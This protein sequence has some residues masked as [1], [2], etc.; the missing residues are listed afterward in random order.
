MVI[1]KI[2]IHE[3]SAMSS[4]NLV[5]PKQRWPLIE[6]VESWWKTY[7]H[8]L[9]FPKRL[10]KRRDWWDTHWCPNFHALSL[11]I[12]RQVDSVA[13]PGGMK[14]CCPEQVPCIGFAPSCFSLPAPQVLIPGI[15][16]QKS[17]LYMNQALIARP[18]QA[19]SGNCR[20]IF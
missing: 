19:T 16:S 4:T 12:Y 11:A 1:A 2:T 10:L 5:I 17:L 8:Q 14:T 9:F 3:T 6:Y 7:T 13:I 20:E 15:T 18:N